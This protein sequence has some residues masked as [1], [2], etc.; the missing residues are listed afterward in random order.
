MK[1]LWLLLTVWTLSAP[2]AVEWRNLDAAHALGG[3]KAS[4]G[5][6]QGKVVLVAHWCAGDPAGWKLAERLEEVW[7]SFKN[8]QFVMLGAPL[9]CDAAG[10]SLRLPTAGEGVS[11]PL[12]ADAGLGAGEPH[13]GRLPLLY[14]VDETGR[15]VYLGHDERNAT[16][17]VVTALTD[18]DAPK[19]PKQ[20]RRFL[21]YELENLPARAYNRLADFKRKLPGEAKAY[22]ERE[23]E[24]ARIPDVK[25]VAELV[26]FAKRAKDAPTFGPRDGQKREKFLA[27]VRSVLRKSASLKETSDAR[28]VREAKN[29]LADLAWTEA[30]L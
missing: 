6:L 28:L 23:R 22:A 1:T 3:R 8:K 18:M 29:A 27:L 17:A 14:V 10:G 20:W 4:A 2:A 15:V 30:A 25:K 12:Y 5:Y 26:A 19:S 9:D 7:Q 16:Q 11:F 13:T 21:D 24:L